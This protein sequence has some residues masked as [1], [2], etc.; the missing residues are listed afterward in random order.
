[1]LGFELTINGEKVSAALEHGVVSLIT[2]QISKDGINSI[3]LDLKGLDIA[4]LN[5]D[6]KIDWYNKIL[7]EGDEFS[8]KVKD[9]IDNSPPCKLIEVKRKT[10]DERKLASYEALKKELEEKGLI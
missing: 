3:E 4:E 6:K 5:K 10:R 9:I 1:M 2:T 7:N 8:V